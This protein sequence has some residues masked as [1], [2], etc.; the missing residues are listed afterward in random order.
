MLR[1]LVWVVFPSKYLFT[2]IALSIQQRMYGRNWSSSSIYCDIFQLWWGWLSSIFWIGAK[3]FSSI[4][5]LLFNSRWDIRSCGKLILSD[6]LVSCLSWP[7]L[8]RLWFD[9]K[10]SLIALVLQRIFDMVA[11]P[12]LMIGFSLA[13]S[14][15]SNFS[16]WTTPN[17]KE[18]ISSSSMMLF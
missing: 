3:G 18:A 9:E 10:V 14:N 5:L 12:W 7:R 6:I 16:F 1:F 17:A 8:L 4:L 2:M 13:I 11:H 15:N